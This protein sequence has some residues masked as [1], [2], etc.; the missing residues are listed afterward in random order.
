VYGLVAIVLGGNLASFLFNRQVWPY[1]P[2]PMFADV[3]DPH[4]FETLA[5]VGEPVD[6]GEIRETGFP[7]WILVEQTTRSLLAGHYWYTSRNR[8]LWRSGRSCCRSMRGPAW[9]SL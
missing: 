2:Y 6:G 9:H 7:E 3:E 5:L 4:N 8:A 1:S